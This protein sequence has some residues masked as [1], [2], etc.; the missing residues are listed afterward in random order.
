LFEFL[1]ACHLK[2]TQS[3]VKVLDEQTKQIRDQLLFGPLRIFPGRLSVS[4][5]FG[6][7][8]AKRKKLGGNPGVLIV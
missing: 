6:D 3:L 8:E 7:V 5:A 2:R 1:T 4:R